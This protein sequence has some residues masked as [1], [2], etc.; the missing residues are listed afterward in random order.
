MFVWFETS[1]CLNSKMSYKFEQDP[2]GIHSIFQMDP[3]SN[4]YLNLAPDLYHHNR[5]SKNLR[6]KATKQTYFHH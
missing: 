3:D 5:N 4:L 2:V 1:N 6:M